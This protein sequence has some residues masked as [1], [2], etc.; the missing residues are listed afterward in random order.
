MQCF[1]WM[2]YEPVRH[3]GI[4]VEVKLLFVFDFNCHIYIYVCAPSYWMMNDD[5]SNRDHHDYSVNIEDGVIF[6]FPLAWG[7]TLN[8][9]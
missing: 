7:I 2:T 5:P 8:D 1:S 4:L 9:K 6:H 3:I